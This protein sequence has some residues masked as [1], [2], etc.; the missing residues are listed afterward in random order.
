MVIIHVIW[1]PYFCLVGLF[2][3]YIIFLKP[4]IMLFIFYDCFSL[5][6]CWE[7]FNIFSPFLSSLIP[8]FPFNCISSLSLLC[9]FTLYIPSHIGITGHK[10]ADS[11]KKGV[12]WNIT[13]KTGIGMSELKPEI[14][15]QIQNEWQ[16]R[17]K[18]SS[19]G[20]HAHSILRPPDGRLQIKAYQRSPINNKYNEATTR[21]SWLPAHKNITRLRLG[22]ADFQHT[23]I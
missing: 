9:S 13:V 11:S 14:K 23:K 3:R 8:S 12:G 10:S 17:W 20:R 4:F 22:S 7:F 18:E 2:M 16:Q 15:F 21:V 6:F 5:G 19:S 1:V